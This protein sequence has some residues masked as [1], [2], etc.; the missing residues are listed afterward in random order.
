MC[1]IRRLP[2]PAALASLL[3]ISAIFPAAGGRFTARLQSTHADP[4]ASGRVVW[5]AGPEGREPRLRIRVKKVTSTNLAVAFIDER[6]AG[7]FPIV[8]G[9]GELHQVRLRADGG[10]IPAVRASSTVEVF[11][12]EDQ[13]L[14]LRSPV[15]KG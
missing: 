9:T 10:R 5:Q 4:Q 15:G 14:I 13:V 7:E 11:A 1:G 3:G 8:K 2:G 6:F 12:L